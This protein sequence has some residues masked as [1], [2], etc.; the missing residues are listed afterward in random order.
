MHILNVYSEIWTKFRLLW[1]LYH[2]HIFHT[3]LSRDIS[4]FYGTNSNFS[5]NKIFLRCHFCIKAYP[6][7]RGRCNWCIVS[8]VHCPRDANMLLDR[9]ASTTARIV[10]SSL[11]IL[12]VVQS[13]C[14][15]VTSSNVSNFIFTQW[16]STI[17]FW[18]F[19]S[20]LLFNT[21]TFV[22]R[23]LFPF[24]FKFCQ[25]SPRICISRGR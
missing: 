4:L 10:P 3:Y 6:S 23:S 13:R 9:F 7:Y 22:R 16:K 15:K 24:N 8:S 19:S 11:E 5:I 17:P 18:S 14:Y 21:C 1:P 20:L 2:A 25:A 12:D